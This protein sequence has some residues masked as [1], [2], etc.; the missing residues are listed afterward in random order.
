VRDPA[1]LAVV[2]DAAAQDPA[3]PDPAAPG[4]ADE[5]LVADAATIAPL[6]RTEPTTTRSARM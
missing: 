1:A 2:P 4:G 5:E 3:A 6:S